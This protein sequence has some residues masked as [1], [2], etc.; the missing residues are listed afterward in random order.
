MPRG[1][2]RDVYCDDC[3]Q[4]MESGEQS[5]DCCQKCKTKRRSVKLAKIRAD[6]GLPPFG[7]G[8]R[9]PFCSVCHNIK[10][11]RDGGFCNSC[12]RTYNKAKREFDKTIPGFVESERERNKRRR[13]EDALHKFK[14]ASR[15]VT[16]RAIRS[17]HLLKQP[18][19]VCGKMKVDAH[20]DDYAKPLEVRWLCRS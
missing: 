20:H 1:P 14:S 9:S 4:R 11:R 7:S 19:E 5:K 6:R 8:L 18:C 10:E 17:G 13:D 2:K 16:Q 3:T 12:K 15:A